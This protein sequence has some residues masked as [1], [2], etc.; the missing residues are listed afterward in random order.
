MPRGV[1]TKALRPVLERLFSKVEKTPTCWLWHGSKG[2]AGHGQ[3]L[4]WVDGNRRLTGT[5]RVAWECLVGPIPAGALVLHKCDVP[6]CVN[7][8]HLFLG[9]HDDNTKDMISKG[10]MAVGFALPQTRLS[11][12]ERRE[13]AMAAGTQAGIAK[14]FG[15]AQSYVCELKKR[16]AGV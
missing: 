12:E 3:I 13:I 7:P 15:V 10:R 2:H 5:H 9:S 8:D 16:Y 6:N 1:Y 14:R 11:D 4:V